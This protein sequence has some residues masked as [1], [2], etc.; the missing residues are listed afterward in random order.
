[1][2]ENHSLA[3]IA[4]Y[5]LSKFDAAGYQALGFTNK[6]TAHKEI[7]KLLGVNPNSIK[8]MRD[9]FDPLHENARA[10][11]YQRPLRPSRAKVVESLQNLSEI[12]LRDLVLEILTNPNFESSDDYADIINSISSRDIEKK[13]L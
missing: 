7:G 10:G 13:K 8:N 2:K 3:L 5:Y 4:A 6:T 11:W 1:M 12:E 9:E